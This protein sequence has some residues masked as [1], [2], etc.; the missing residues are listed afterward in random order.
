M[1]FNDYIQNPMGINNA[2]FSGRDMYRKMYEDKWKNIKLRENGITKYNLYLGKRE[3]IVHFKIPSEI[4]PQFYY[5]VI[6]RFTT[7]RERTSV[8]ME[9]TL[10]N[11]D[12]QFYSNDPSF[13]FTFAHAFMK[14]GML[15]RD[16]D[17]K[18]SNRALTQKAEMRN[19]KN[20][21]G[22]VK[23]LYFAYLEMKQLGLFNKNAWDGKAHTYNK[24][25]AW[26]DV[27]PADE[28][29]HDRQIKGQAIQKKESRARH[30]EY[31]NKRRTLLDLKKPFG[32]PNIK[33]FGHFAST[34][35]SNI[36]KSIPKGIGHFK[37]D[38]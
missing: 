4:V 1:T 20:Q 3:F 33:N 34:V 8:T 11:Y 24:D 31:E 27:T 18:M 22:Y 2:V 36:S 30:K 38:K 6:V 23:S 12:V 15:F 28:K 25:I 9:T 37:N 26:K 32:S 29:I 17:N 7:P 35:K 19:P 10:N 21:I 14:N 16:L 5:D 13:V